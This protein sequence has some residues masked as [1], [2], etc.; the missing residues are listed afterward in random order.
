[1]AARAAQPWRRDPTDPPPN[2][3]KAAGDTGGGVRVVA[4]PDRPDD[5]LLVGRRAGERVP[6]R[7]EGVDDEAAA[8]PARPCFE[9][10]QRGDAV[11][12]RPLGGPVVVD[13]RE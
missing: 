1:M 6:C 12:A 2:A 5:R 4:V 11:F 3:G 13:V 9:F 8:A 7:P 10:V